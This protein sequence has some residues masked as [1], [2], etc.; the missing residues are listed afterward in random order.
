[1]PIADHAVDAAWS[2]GVLCTMDD[3]LGLLT[4]LRRVVRP[5]GRIGLIVYLATTHIADDEQPDGNRFPTIA[6]LEDLFHKARL[7]VVAQQRAAELDATS[8]DWQRRVD[9]VEAEVEKRHGHQKAWEL[10][11]QQSALLGDLIGE[12]TVQATLFSL[13]HS[14]IDPSR[15]G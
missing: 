15:T 13:R 11:E 5:P 2:L 9:D 14:S 8:T 3:Q 7:T 1:M 12:G 6:P 10:A 4:E